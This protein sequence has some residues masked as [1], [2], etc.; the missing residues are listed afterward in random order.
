MDNLQ[1]M[2]K[3]SETFPSWDTV[4]A[5]LLNYDLYSPQV[6]FIFHNKMTEIIYLSRELKMFSVCSS[7]NIH[8]LRYL[9]LKVFRLQSLATSSDLRHSW[10]TAVI[11]FSQ[12]TS[13]TSTLFKFQTSFPFWDTVFTNQHTPSPL[14][15]LLLPSREYSNGRVRSNF[16]RKEHS[17]S[18]W[19]WIEDAEDYSFQ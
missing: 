9:A 10:S 19:L 2:F 6:T 13:Y 17:R 4:S 3:I 14:R 11:V 5:K 12:W 1:T 15:T 18:H 7:S 8:F 16:V